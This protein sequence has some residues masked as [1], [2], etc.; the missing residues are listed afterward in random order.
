MGDARFSLLNAN[1]YAL[2]LIGGVDLTLDEWVTVSGVSLQGADN[3]LLV[4]GDIEA[5][6]FTDGVIVTGDDNVVTVTGDIDTAGNGTWGINGADG[7]RNT[8]R[9]T[10]DIRIG[11][12]ASSGGRGIS[13]INGS[14]N[15]VE[16]DESA[17]IFVRTA[18]GRGISLGGI[19]DSFIY[20][21]DDSTIYMESADSY[22]IYS[23][24]DRNEIHFGDGALI[25]L[26]G[27]DSM[28]VYVEGDE[29]LI[30]LA[31]GGIYTYEA[32]SGG[33]RVEGSRNE[34]TLREHANIRTEGDLAQ[35]ITIAGAG[36]DENTIT[37]LGTITAIGDDSAGVRVDDASRNTVTL[38]GDGSIV[39][40]GDNG[41]AIYASGGGNS[42]FVGADAGIQ[43]EG[44][45]TRGI[46]ARDGDNIVDLHGQII[47]D[48]GFTAIQVTGADNVVTVH[49]TGLIRVL[50]SGY[51]IYS[52][53]SAT[54]ITVAGTI[55][56]LDGNSKG[57]AARLAGHVITLTGTGSIRTEGDVSSP[58]EYAGITVQ[59]GDD[60]QVI[61]EDDSS[62][63]T[64]GNGGAHGVLASG[65][66]H[67]ISVLDRASITTHGDSSHGVVTLGSD[68]TINV[69]GNIA[70]NGEY[71]NAIHA[72][73]NGSIIDVAGTITTL[74]ND[75][76]GI[77]VEG[78]GS[79]VTL[80][81]SIQTSG[82]F[83]AEGI[84]VDGENN[85][86]TL[87]GGA[88]ITSGDKGIGLDGA[89]GNTVIMEAG[90]VI[91]ITGDQDA[92]F[93][94]GAGNEYRIGGHI[95][96]GLDYARG[97]ALGDADGI[98]TLED[99][100]LIHTQG[101]GAVGV[102][103][104]G[105]AGGHDIAI[106]GTIRTEGGEAHGVTGVGD[107]N[108]VILSGTISTLG[109]DADG[110]NFDTGTTGNR[111]ELHS[112]FTLSTGGSLAQ[113]GGS[114]T[115]SLGGTLDGSFDISQIGATNGYVGF[116]DFDKRGTSTWTLTGTNNA[117]NWTVREGTML[118]SGDAGATDVL[119]GAILGGT[120]AVGD[121]VVN[122]GGRLVG[123]QG[124]TLTLASLDLDAGSFIDV[125]LGLPGT[126]A[127]F[128]VTNDLTLDGTLN[129]ADAGG[130]GSG[131]GLYRLFDYGGTLDDHGLDIGSVPAGT[132]ASNL[133]V[134]TS[135]AQQVNLYHD[136]GGG[137]GG[138][139]L[140]WDG[141]LPGNAANGAIDGGDGQW[142][143]TNAN[144]TNADGSA[145]GA[146][147]PVPGFVAFTGAAGFVQADDSDGPLSV[148]GMQFA[149]HAYVVQGD[150]IELAGLG[151][152]A[153]IRVGDGTAAGAGYG[154]RIESELTGAARLVK[155]DLGTLIL[156]GAN[157][158]AGGTLINAGV[159]QVSSD[160][161]LGLAAGDLAFNGGTLAT[162]ASFDSGRDVN[163]LADGRFDVAAA[164]ALE[165]DG[166]VSGSGA[167]I[168]QGAGALVLSGSNAY[169]GTIVEAGTLT[170]HSGS[171]TGDI[172]NAGTVV[173][174]QATDGTFA[175]DIAGH[176]G[177]AGMMIKDGAGVLTLT[178]TSSLD[179]AIGAGSV[180]TAAERFTGDA[181]LA[182]GGELVFDRAADATSG[183]LLS[184]DGTGTFAKTGTGLLT[185]T[186]AN[187]GFT[188]HTNIDGGTLFV[189]DALGGTLD[190]NATGI[191]AGN[192]TVGTAVVRNGGT[193]SP[194]AAGQIDTLHVAGGLTF[195]AGSTY[196]VHVDAPDQA[197]LISVAGTA[198]VDGG[199]VQVEKLSAETS[200]MDGQTYRLL[201]ATSLVDNAGFTLNQPFLFLDAEL[202]YGGNFVDLEL[203]RSGSFSD[204]ALTFNQ[205]QAATALD[206]LEQNGDALGVFNE[207]LAM[208]DT[209]AARRA[210]DLT[211]GEIH[212]TGRH[213]INQTFRLFSRTLRQQ[214]SAGVG[215][216]LAG[217]EVVST[218]MNMLS[219]YGPSTPRSLGVRAIDSAAGAYA[220]ARVQGAW[221]APFGARGT[222]DG[223]GNAGALDWWTLGIA[224]GYEG[225]VD[226]GGGEAV[227]GLA[228]GYLRSGGTIDARMSSMDA[229]GFHLGAYGAWTDGQWSLAGSAAYAAN[230][231]STQRRIAFG[232]IDRSAEASYWNHTVGLST[233]LAYAIETN[234]GLTISPLF[235]LDAGWTGHG[236]YSETGAGALGLTAAGQGYGW[237][238]TGLG[239]SLA[240]TIETESGKV[241]FDG[242][243][244][245]EHAF[246]GAVPGADHLLAGSPVGFS[247]SG[248]DAGNDRL[249]LGAGVAFGIGD[250]LTIRARYDGLF[251]GSQQSHAGS[252]GLNVRF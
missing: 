52:Q 88:S 223:D 83:S 208:T 221:A 18:S 66:R 231:V 96:T 224:G 220:D 129:I 16:L 121:T 241:T 148:T 141:D 117:A 145:N 106:H 217:T 239:I 70:T 45:L 113:G 84:Y 168:K 214:A 147:S 103:D 107:G 12:A 139:F 177:S 158:Y 196:V 244:V 63:E 210:Y 92:I 76:A 213:V 128:D 203:T 95:L 185:L 8:Y 205:F 58:L 27:S 238:D 53:D 174:A 89:G 31:D 104:A 227:A 44:S 39:V 49:E 153:I 72:R 122:A 60:N 77:K 144:W 33:V 15:R 182:T 189:S 167:L 159:L 246:A 134:L 191:L 123:V 190:I 138:D 140:L 36:S 24:G 171:I 143:R 28:G 86:V 234:S 169:G 87:A 251:S 62:I 111:L 80:S 142:N 250:G 105:G 21:N 130:F 151:G 176:A 242:R 132:D 197:D 19:T 109:V 157:S 230:Y 47:S 51:G 120:G 237:L 67:S 135:V 180:V 228:F 42:I 173:F 54:D 98:V 65:N 175:G 248:P 79:I 4:E 5:S 32:G 152:D 93:G 124:Q 75:A 118:V 61:L 218:P 81:G 219:A 17:E 161:N 232:A 102:D 188:G 137:G 154:A 194:G 125:S 30:N 198:T 73:G 247:V 186:G 126:T 183:I 7:D 46:Y 6:P 35:G 110:I 22:G 10:G 206:G 201:T 243:A 179:W 184:G 43:I 112:G 57:I 229:D 233:E 71:A 207:L 225:I 245:W 192:G 204:V 199:A 64:F 164:T 211:S 78:E 131:P 37:V 162:T 68:N 115:L 3:V 235:T 69:T 48:D 94:Y 85:T 74:N 29:N 82:S 116:A 25:T 14:I 195:E 55:E 1:G 99:T 209:D 222:I 249:R 13:L 172:A 127:L 100:G 156:T 252:L 114:G 20:L 166:T 119:S 50:G 216:G 34:I 200:Y 215:N 165:L 26:D 41:Y 146:M 23:A 108:T 160:G 56:V 181:T 133:E 193:I 38:D 187:S 149:T 170:G 97:I 11:D 178:G 212:A 155:N 136:A 226:V 236:G 240:H 59:G 163:L 90:S 150:A 101:Y 2:N 202:I 9:V 40:S 91:D